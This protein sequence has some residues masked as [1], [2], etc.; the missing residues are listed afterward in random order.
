MDPRHEGGERVGELGLVVV[1]LLR[2]RRP[3]LVRGRRRRQ[4]SRRAE[5]G[6]RGGQ[7]EL[8]ERLCPVTPTTRAPPQKAASGAGVGAGHTTYAPAG[9]EWSWAGGLRARRPAAGERRAGGEEAGK[10]RRERAA[11]KVRGKGRRERELHARGPLKENR[12]ERGRWVA[13]CR[14]FRMQN[15]APAPLGKTQAAGFVLGAQAQNVALFG[16]N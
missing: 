16:A 4:S 13:D 3:H 15:I 7:L 11:R 6:A 9:G 14:P 8:R 1:P 12:G 2:R 5:G 10:G